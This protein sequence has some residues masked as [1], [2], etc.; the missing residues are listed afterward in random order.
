MK[1]ALHGKST[2]AVEITNVSSHGFWLMLGGRELFLSFDL[3]PWFRQAAIGQLC[4]VELPRP[5]HLWWPDL[6][7]DLAEESIEHPERFPVVSHRRPNK[8]MRRKRTRVTTRRSAR[9]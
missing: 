9:G 6:D 2:S 8:G 3:F 5:G 7:I 1:S 4:N